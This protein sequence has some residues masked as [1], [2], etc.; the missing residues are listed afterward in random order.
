MCEVNQTQVTQIHLLRFRS[1]AKFK[2][3]LFIVVILTYL[4]ILCGNLIIII[5]VTTVDPLKIPMFFLKNLAT[6]DILLTTSLV[7]MMLDIPF[8]EEG[9][10]S[11]V[12]CITQLYTFGIFG[13]VQCFQIAVMSYDQ[14][15][16]LCKPLHYASLLNPHVCLQLVLGSWFLVTLLTSSEFM[17]VVQFN[18][19]GINYIDHFVCDLEPIIELSTSDTSSLML[20]DFELSIFVIFCPFT[21]IIITYMYIFFIILQTSSA[22]SRRKAF[23]TCSS[24][25]ATV[26]AYYGTLITVYMVP[27]DDSTASINKYRSLVY[28][29]V[30]PLINPII[31]SLRNQKIKKALLKFVIKLKTDSLKF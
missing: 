12:G 16:A 7:P 2:T 4:I 15:L 8:I 21:F 20:Q 29:V 10:L 28:I 5:V 18:F 6:A 17:V 24:H 25:L 1:L 13:F 3:L 26:C 30:K 22:Y 14:Y 31:H 23:S 27:G 9:R 19:F 11:F